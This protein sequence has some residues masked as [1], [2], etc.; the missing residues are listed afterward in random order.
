[1]KKEFIIYL[2]SIDITNAHRGRVETIYKFYQEI[3][4]DEITGIFITDYIEKDGSREY[5]NLWFFSEECCMEAKQFITKDDFDITPIK[6]RVLYWTIQKQ[7]YD[8]KKATKKSRLYLKLVLDTGIEGEL[9]AA[10]ENCDYLR[11]I[12]LKYVV[13]NLKE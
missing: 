2:K 13:P 6:K 8:F 10:K 7:D 9:K 4:P 11:K 5:E 1:M 3:C 12:I